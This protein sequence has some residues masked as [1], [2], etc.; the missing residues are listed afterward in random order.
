M[1]LLFSA[2]VGCH[3]RSFFHD[4]YDA[5]D[6]VDP[7]D[8][9]LAVLA[10]LSFFFCPWIGSKT[11]RLEPPRRCAARSHSKR[12]DQASYSLNFH[13]YNLAAAAADPRFDGDSFDIRYC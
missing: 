6:A 5:A 11:R 9:M 13:I 3:P 2:V 10:A 4:S 7:L 1:F 8:R 12:K